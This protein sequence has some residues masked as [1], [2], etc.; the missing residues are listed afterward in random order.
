MRH[1]LE[2][3][4]LFNFIAMPVTPCLTTCVP[5][6]L[7]GLPDPNCSPGLRQTTPARLGMYNCD[8]DLP[9]GSQSAINAAMLA[10]ANSGD[11]VFSNALFNVVFEDPTYEEIGVDD[12]QYPFQSL[13]TRAMTFEDRYIQDISAISPFIANNFFDY[14]YWL[15]KLQ[16]QRNIRFLIGYCNG[17]F[18]KVDF[19]G[20][21]RGYVNYIKPSQIGAVATETKQFRLVFNGDPLAMNNTT[22]FNAIDAGIIL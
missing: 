16:N 22:F 7:I 9:T 14:T 1:R 12:C 8:I 18:R 3:N 6:Q 5:S 20:S 19:A 2:L 11:L 17:D 13:Q 10:L 4:H 15:D 21:L